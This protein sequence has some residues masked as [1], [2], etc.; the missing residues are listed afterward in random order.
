MKEVWRSDRK[1]PNK[2]RAQFTHGE[3]ALEIACEWMLS[4]PDMACLIAY[5]PV[6]GCPKLPRNL[7][8]RGPAIHP[9]I[10]PS[11][12]GH[13]DL[14]VKSD[15]SVDGSHTSHIMWAN[16]RP[17][18]RRTARQAQQHVTEGRLCANRIGPRVRGQV[19]VG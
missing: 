16:G 14:S 15:T 1:A 11:L 6:L 12:W 13:Q 17:S 18:A 7:L 10:H 3:G 5:K 4:R 19:P 2:I 9:P 8:S